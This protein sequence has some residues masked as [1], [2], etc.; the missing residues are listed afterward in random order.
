ME[1]KQKVGLSKSDWI[2][3][4]GGIILLTLLIVL[5]PIFRIV[6]EEEKQPAVDSND[7]IVETTPSNREEE[8]SDSIYSKITCINQ[9]T[10]PE[11]IENSTIII[12]HEN[13]MLKVLTEDTTNTY[14]LNSK[15]SESM[16]TQE[17]LACN[18]LP[19]VFHQIK[20]YNYSCNVSETSV[21][22]TKKY[23]LNKFKPIT[24]NDHEGVST[25][26]T[27]L[28]SINQSTTDIITSLTSEGY[29]C[30]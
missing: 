25:S 23:D 13:N 2:L 9:L 21:Q 8:I 24:V 28:Y 10:H 3:S 18:N 11:Y 15:E 19:D 20:G 16:Y 14:L 6:F 5:P 30:E 26:I 7:T 1:N 27:T 17:K 4:I 22:T 29:T 12:A